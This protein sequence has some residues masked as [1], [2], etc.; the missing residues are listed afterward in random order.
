[1]GR[2][3][4]RERKVSG[5][6]KFAGANAP[7][8]LLETTP[9]RVRVFFGGRIV[10]DS[11]RVR[12]LYHG[13]PAPDYYF[14]KE[15][16]RHDLL[17]ATDHTTKCPVRGHA[18]YWS[19]VAGKRKAENVVWEYHDPPQDIPDISGL[20]SFDWDGMD[21]W[22]EEEEEVFVH[23]RDPYHRIDVR[24]SAR[25][26]QV[27]VGDTLVAD[28]RRPV[29]LFETG[30][31]VR[32]YLPRLD[33]RTDLLEE[34]GTETACPYKGVTSAYWGPGELTEEEDR[35]LAWCYER[36][37]PG[38]EKIAGRIAFFNE[39]VDLDVDDERQDRPKT[40]WS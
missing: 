22:F 3:G 6:R 21:A 5:V 26:V 35:D 33:V 31:P 2:E 24:E 34:R 1:M 13:G 11:T 8:V 12:L 38:M 19:V 40:V 9:K 20:L 16:V 27:R 7:E 17:E 32:Y 15:D 25:H 36:P 28:S 30:L 39:R 14:P 37:L 29:L 10:A 18:R 23:P 4:E